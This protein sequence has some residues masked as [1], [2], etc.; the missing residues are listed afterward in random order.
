RVLAERVRAGVD[1]RIIG[2]IGSRET[3]VTAQKYPG[4]RL[5]VRAIVRDGNR[6]FLGSQSLRKLEL[7][8]RREVGLIVDDAAVVHGIQR[9]FE[10]DWALTP[11]AQK[12]PPPE[13]QAPHEE[14]KTE[15]VPAGA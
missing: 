10:Q 2:K 14:P 13:E 3:T 11:A 12:G 7:E 6:A 4:K 9:V 15:G 1:V 8:R 5:H